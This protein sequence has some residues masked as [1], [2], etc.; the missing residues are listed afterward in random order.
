[1]SGELW[2]R[3]FL[4]HVSLSPEGRRYGGET[5]CDCGDSLGV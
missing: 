2:L 3:E 1:M 4:W 5:C